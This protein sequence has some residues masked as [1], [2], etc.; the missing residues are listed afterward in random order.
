MNST[1]RITPVETTPR[2][3][4][5]FSSVRAGLRLTMVETMMLSG[6][7]APPSRSALG[8]ESATAA[9]LTVAVNDPALRVAVGAERP[10]VADVAV[11]VKLAVAVAV[12]ALRLTVAAVAD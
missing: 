5:P 2:T 8:A 11:R 1:V 3:G 4:D 12:G 6:S 10:M 9:A 7:S